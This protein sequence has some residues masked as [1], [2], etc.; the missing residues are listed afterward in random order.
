[1]GHSA[2]E[3]LLLLLLL[4]LLFLLLRQDQKMC[5]FSAYITVYALILH[6]YKARNGRTDNYFTRTRRKS[7]RFLKACAGLAEIL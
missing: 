4:L 3:E 2:I 6:V 1:M 5:D 7:E